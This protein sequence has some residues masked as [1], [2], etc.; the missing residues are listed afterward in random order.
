MTPSIIKLAQVRSGPLATPVS[1]YTVPAAPPST[2][3]EVQAIWLANTDN[4]THGITL[5]CGIGTLT[6]ANSLIEDSQIPGFTTYI[7]NGERIA[8]LMAG[9]SL[10]ASDDGGGSRFTIT[11]YGALIRP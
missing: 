5:R 7:I 3:A 6:I 1:V 4:S 9:E 8:V 11:L 2:V 10:Q